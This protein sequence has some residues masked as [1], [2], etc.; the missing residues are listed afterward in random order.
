MSLRKWLIIN[1]RGVSSS[2]KSVSVVGR[3]SDLA[4]DRLVGS[5]G[6]NSEFYRTNRLHFGVS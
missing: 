2:D 3:V 6:Q 5:G 1:D 4:S